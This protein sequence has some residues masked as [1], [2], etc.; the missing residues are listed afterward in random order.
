M[1]AD[2]SGVFILFGSLSG[3]LVGCIALNHAQRARLEKKLESEGRVV[4]CYIL[5][6]NKVLYDGNQQGDNYAQVIFS[7]E[8][9]SQTSLPQIE[10]FMQ[11]VCRGLKDFRPAKGGEAD[12][13]V[14]ADVLRTQKVL[15]RKTSSANSFANFREYANLYGA[16]CYTAQQTCRQ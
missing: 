13:R 4:P 6:A 14:L 9:N 16:N 5:T 12:E 7:R 8:Y 2:F 3:L 1:Q 15:F 11:K 10:P